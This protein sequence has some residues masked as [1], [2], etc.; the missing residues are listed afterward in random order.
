MYLSKMQGIE[1]P[2]IRSC[3]VEDYQI[4]LVALSP[5]VHMLMEVLFLQMPNFV[6]VCYWPALLGS[7]DGICLF[8]KSE[9]K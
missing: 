2:Q 5:W 7:S 6:V 1:F 9:P 4:I 3:E 8:F